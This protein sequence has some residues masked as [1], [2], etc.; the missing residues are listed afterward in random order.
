MSKARLT[1]EQK[2]EVRLLHKE[3]WNYSRI[4][5]KIGVRRET[6]MRLLDDEYADRRRRQINEARHRREIGTPNAIGRPAATPLTT[7]V[8]GAARLAEVPRDT[9]D[10]T[11]RLCGDPLPGRDALSK[12]R[13]GAST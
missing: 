8:D 3:G 13:S 11:A 4:A 12:A 9:R 6:V 10:L 2:S 1:E 7:R 5:E